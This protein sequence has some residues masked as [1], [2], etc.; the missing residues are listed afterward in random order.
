[1]DVSL[2]PELEQ[3]IQA[4]IGSGHYRD[5]EE[6]IRAG[7]HRLKQ[8]QEIALPRHKTLA[9]LERRLREGIERLDRGEG[10]PGEES[11]RR[12]KEWIKSMTGAHG[13]LHGR[14]ICRR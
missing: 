3:F 13:S 6:V 8:D 7:L 12:M 4:E 14:T 10:I 5:P 11:R 9:D 2:P 1:M